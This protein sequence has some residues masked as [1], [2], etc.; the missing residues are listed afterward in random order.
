MKKSAVFFFFF[1]FPL[2]FATAQVDTTQSIQDY[3]ED[4]LEESTI[5]VEDSQLYDKFE[6]LLQNP[7]NVNQA[8]LDDLLSIPLM[9]V[10]TASLII[11]SFLLLSCLP[12]SIR[13]I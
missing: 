5:D 8:T 2:S 7:I 13:C 3:I 12:W 11:V 1:I 9:D 4:L 6:S 10:E